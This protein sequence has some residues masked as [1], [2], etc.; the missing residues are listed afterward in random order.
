MTNELS[1]KMRDNVAHII[2]QALKNASASV[3]TNVPGFGG[4][5][6]TPPG[7]LE[8]I[9]QGYKTILVTIKNSPDPAAAEAVLKGVKQAPG[10]RIL[11]VDFQ[12]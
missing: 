6:P 11:V 3:V 7:I 2:A 12:E 8:T 1:K 10:M 5:Q 4:S 9:L